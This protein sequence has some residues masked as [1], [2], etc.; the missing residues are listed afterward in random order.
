MVAELYAGAVKFKG[1]WVRVLFKC[2]ID[3]KFKQKGGIT[4]KLSQQTLGRWDIHKLYNGVFNENEMQTII[5]D[6]KFIEVQTLLIKI[7]DEKP[8]IECKE[9][10]DIYGILN[11]CELERIE[12][13]ERK[14]VIQNNFKEFGASN[15]DDFL[16]QQMQMML[17]Y[18][19]NKKQTTNTKQKFVGKNY[20]FRDD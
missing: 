17:Q 15:Q 3:P 11:G 1:K 8:T 18:E 19:R 16:K 9:Y 13:Q 4:A 6:P 20:H 7:H 12:E 14:N 2:R 5:P 10:K